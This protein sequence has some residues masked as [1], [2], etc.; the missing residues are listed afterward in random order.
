M[1]EDQ[2]SSSDSEDDTE[3]HNAFDEFIA[4][5]NLREFLYLVLILPYIIVTT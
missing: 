4:Q 2:S 5:N 3:V 1:L